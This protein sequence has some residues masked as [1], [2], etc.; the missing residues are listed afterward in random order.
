VGTFD[1]YILSFVK[2]INW[3]EELMWIK[4]MLFNYRVKPSLLKS[5]YEI[6]KENRQ[7]DLF[8]SS[9][10]MSKSVSIRDTRSYIQQ[11]LAE[12]QMEFIQPNTKTLED[13]FNYLAA[14]R[15]K[16]T[17]SVDNNKMLWPLISK[18]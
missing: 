1:C 11:N 4:K 16:P 5:R 2:Q 3:E 7:V 14:I 9:T 12:V 13:M 17:L 18:W 10:E 8:E 15:E 6:E